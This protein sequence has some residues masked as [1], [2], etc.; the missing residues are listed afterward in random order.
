LATE[1]GDQGSLQDVRDSELQRMLAECAAWSVAMHDFRGSLVTPAA[2]TL[3]RVLIQA[4]THTVAD[5][6]KR[7]EGEILG[8]ANSATSD[9][10]PAPG[11]I[12]QSLNSEDKSRTSD[13]RALA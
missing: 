9:A 7:I 13:D 11:E 4:E 6:R 8:R 10:V 3:W 2:L 5:A 1:Y 12:L